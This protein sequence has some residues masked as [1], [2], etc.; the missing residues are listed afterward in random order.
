MTEDETAITA[1][2]QEHSEEAQSVRVIVQQEI[3]ATLVDMVGHLTSPEEHQPPGTTA[4]PST[5]QTGESQD[6]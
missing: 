2:T 1:P 3:W 6:I 4:Q 5:Q